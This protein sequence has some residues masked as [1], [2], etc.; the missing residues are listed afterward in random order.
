L[1]CGCKYG[2]QD[3]RIIKS[4][5]YSLKLHPNDP[6]LNLTVQEHECML[7]SLI[8]EGGGFSNQIGLKFLLNPL[9]HLIAGTNNLDS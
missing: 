9:V 5:W 1:L 8:E 6:N 2:S 7:Y 3:Y 4:K